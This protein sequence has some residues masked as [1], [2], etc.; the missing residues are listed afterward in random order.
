MRVLPSLRVPSPSLFLSPV[1]ACLAT[2]LPHPVLRLCSD[3]RRRQ[4]LLPQGILRPARR[5]GHTPS[6]PAG[7]TR[8]RGPGPLYTVHRDLDGHVGMDVA[9]VT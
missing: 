6:R 9:L 2:P 3:S 7:R 8:P 5:A 4:V 1:A